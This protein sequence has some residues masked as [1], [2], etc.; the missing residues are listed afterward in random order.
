MK[1]FIFLFV[2]LNLSLFSQVTLAQNEKNY[3]DLGNMYN[4][5]N[6]YYDSNNYIKAEEEY[7]KIINHG[8]DNGYV[9]YNLGNTYAKLGQNGLAIANYKKAENFI[10]RERNLSFNLKSMYQKIDYEENIYESISKPFKYLTFKENIILFN[11]IWL[12]IFLILIVNKSNKFNFKNKSQLNKAF[13]VLSPILIYSIVSISLKIYEYNKN[14]AIIVVQESDVK[15][16][17]NFSDLTLFKVK[18]NQRVNVISEL[19]DWAK[20]SFEG[21]NG[22]INKASLEKFTL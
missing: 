6:K 1:K 7:K 10:P 16:S 21:N 4:N 2:F 9:Y 14:E 8:L 15:V 3:S 13:L 18:E 22:W 12:A 5:A 19:G 17:N 20:I 11:F